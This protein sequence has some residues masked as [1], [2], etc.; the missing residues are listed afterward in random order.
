M[1][2]HTGVS[3]W[4]YTISNSLGNVSSKGCEARPESVYVYL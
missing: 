3:K 1:Y 2:V 4:R